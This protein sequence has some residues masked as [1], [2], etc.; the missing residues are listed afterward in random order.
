MQRGV[1]RGRER[2]GLRE[3]KIEEGIECL[4]EQEWVN[5][6][7]WEGG[8]DV[9]WRWKRKGRRRVHRKKVGSENVRR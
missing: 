1:N 6:V 9:L 8:G 2:K 3:G 5:G 4:S 7:C